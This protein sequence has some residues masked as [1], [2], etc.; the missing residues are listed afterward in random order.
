MVF[1]RR[2]SCEFS[3]YCSQYIIDSDDENRERTREIQLLS[4]LSPV[5]IIRYDSAISAI[6]SYDVFL[7]GWTQTDG[8]AYIC[9]D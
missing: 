4:D 3:Q 8:E 7:S 6:S 2:N 9:I 1:N 5:G